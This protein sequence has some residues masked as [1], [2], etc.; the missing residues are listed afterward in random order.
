VKNN[1]SLFTLG[2]AGIVSCSPV[3][4]GK[5]P[6]IARYHGDAKAAFSYTFDDGF[7]QEVADTL[8][9]LDPLGIK[10][11]F[12]VI[13]QA[14]EEK[15]DNFVTWETLRQMR[16]NGHEIGTHAFTKPKFQ[17]SDDQTVSNIVNGGRA[18]IRDNV[19][20]APVSFAYPGGSL[21]DIPRIQAIVAQHH[22]FVRSKFDGYGSV[23]GRREWTPEKAE[24]RVRQAMEKGDWVVA[25]VHSIINGYS[26]FKSIDEFRG[27]CEWLVAQ[28]DALWIAPMGTVNRYVNE[29]D[30]ATLKILKCS[31]SS[32]QFELVCNLDPAELYNQP[33]TVVIPGV[34]TSTASAV[35][36]EKTF[37]VTLR[38]E[39]LLIDI[40]PSSGPVT[41]EW[42]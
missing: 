11:T 13:P 34:E 39:N 21:T 35:A 29:R 14:I 37:P 38:G 10:G 9:V 24:A 7:R 2:L 27:H 42:K 5:E 16:A 6:H 12:F 31:E 3:A 33:L 15:R 20:T 17:E 19:G 8:S 23:A 41:V 28:G 40:P 1:C 22:P 25:V 4:F 18:A 36:G 30:A 26:P 32:L